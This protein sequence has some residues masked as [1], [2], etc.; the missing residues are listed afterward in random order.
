MGKP[1]AEK[2]EKRLTVTKEMIQKRKAEVAPG[3]RKADTELRRLKKIVRRA[4]SK[5]RRQA[6]PAAGAPAK[7][8]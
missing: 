4:S 8:G 5:K 1:V 3:E 7:E 2:L 6:G